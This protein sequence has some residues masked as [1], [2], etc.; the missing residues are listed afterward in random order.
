MIENAL[1]YRILKE[2]YMQGLS[3]KKIAQI[4][5]VSTATVSRAIKEGI[6]KG[7]V[8][9]SLELPENS[10]PNLEEKIKKRYGINTVYV[11]DIMV[12]DPNIILYDVA[13]AFVNHFNSVINPGDIVGLS[14]GRTLSAI[15]RFLK[16]KEIKDLTFVTL[17][18]G[19]CRDVSETGV[20][21][22]VH[23]FAQPYHAK[24]YSLQLPFYV[25]NQQVAYELKKDKN[26]QFVFNLINEA[27]IAVFS[28]GGLI[29]SS[30][31]YGSGYLDVSDFEEMKKNGFV[32]DICSR[33]Y[34]KDGM[35]VEDD[36]N[37]RS[38]GISLDDLKKKKRKIC[39]VSDPEKAE[40]LNGALNGGYID[41]L[42]VDK[43]TALALLQ[44][45]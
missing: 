8:K 33:F 22:V 42:F 4:E 7:Y 26:I 9:I 27:N 44:I 13:V 16:P 31:L 43:K 29:P 11:S 28:V 34:K 32:G 10:V 41:D 5:G 40:A 45:E 15:A 38:M 1:L 39:I 6:K 21:Q 37:N 17:N 14:W 36:L 23:A 18:G 25:S 12:E 3:Q 2:H 24:A 35:C 19:V 20:E 30:L